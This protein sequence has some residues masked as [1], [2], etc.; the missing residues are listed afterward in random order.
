[1]TNEYLS[2][3]GQNDTNRTFLICTQSFINIQYTYVCTYAVMLLRVI[4]ITW[5]DINETD[6]NEVFLNKW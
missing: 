4:N 2:A 3:V 6:E 5:Y 1:M